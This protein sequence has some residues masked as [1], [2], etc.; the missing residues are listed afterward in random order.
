LGQ[1]F[2]RKGQDIFLGGKI[3]KFVMKNWGKGAGKQ[4]QRTRPENFFP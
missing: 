2:S 4:L 3:P 1:I